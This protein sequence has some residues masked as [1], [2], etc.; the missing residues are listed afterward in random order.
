MH[1]KA[2]IVLLALA[3]GLGLAACGGS[4]KKDSGLSKSALASKANAICK[5][6]TA[7]LSS[8]DAPG[9]INDP[10]AAAKYFG[11][12]APLHQKETDQLAALKPADAAKADWTAF[13]AR[14][15][16]NNA[17]LKT[18]LTKAQNKDASGLDDVK[19]LDAYNTSYGV[20][21]KKVGATQC[22]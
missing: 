14:Q 22:A 2:M 9:D 19:K 10:A 1:R 20:V 17:L 7:S 8:V 6:A 15:N 11:Q 4:S 5:A 18:I 12:V 21:A 3:A 13:M 16:A